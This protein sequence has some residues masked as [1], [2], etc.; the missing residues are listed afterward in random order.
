MFGFIAMS[1]FS[2]CSSSEML[3]RSNGEVISLVLNL[4]NSINVTLSIQK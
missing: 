2:H 4:Q 1:E 3:N